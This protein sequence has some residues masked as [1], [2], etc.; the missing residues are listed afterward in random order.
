MKYSL[1]NNT[2]I[3][4]G[5]F[6]ALSSGVNGGRSNIV[7]IL[8][9]QVAPD[10]NN[11]LPAQYLT[12]LA[13][14]LNIQKPYFGLLTAVSMDNLC[15]STDDY[16][17]TFV[18]AGITHPSP[19]RA[20]TINIILVVK[21]VISEGAMAG[22]VI[23]ATEAKALALLDLGYDFAGTTTDAVIVAYENKPKPYLEYA[24]S[25]TEFAEKIIKTVS[26]GVKKSLK[27]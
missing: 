26:I 19:F 4:E 8:N 7:S 18:T 17:T 15:V 10:F 25:A 11:M 2:L 21:G 16:L 6:E 13:D 20:G 23:T 1:K 5:K 27:S 3:I 9:H 24:G 12:C 14:S 22:A